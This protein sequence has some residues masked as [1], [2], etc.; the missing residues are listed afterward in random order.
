MYHTHWSYFST[1]LAPGPWDPGTLP[2]AS[3]LS[4]CDVDALQ[5]A[6]SPGG[7]FIGGFLDGGVVFV[8]DANQYKYWLVVSNM[9]GLFPISYMGYI[10]LPIDELHHF[11]R[12]LKPPT[13]IG[14]INH[15]KKWVVYDFVLLSGMPFPLQNAMAAMAT[16]E[17]FPVMGGKN[18]IVL[19]TLM[20]I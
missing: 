15:A 17:A 18:Y 16:I 19:P 3:A 6:R 12:W 5:N 1:S 11:S 10:I 7:R 8:V 14:G 20:V 2:Q 9:N 13:R 4:A